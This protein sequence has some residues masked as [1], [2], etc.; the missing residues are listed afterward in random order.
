MMGLWIALVDQERQP[1]AVIDVGV[2]QDHGVEAPGIEGELGVELAGL[3]AAALEEPGVEQHPGP[4][5]LE[6]VH[7][8]GD[9]ARRRRPRR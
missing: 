1:P 8:T 3:R 2:A 4:R 7:G 5:R 6:E 9:L